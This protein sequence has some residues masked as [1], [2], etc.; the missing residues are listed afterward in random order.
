MHFS[1]KHLAQVALS[2]FFSLSVAHV[3]AASVE[4]RA[5]TCNGHPEVRISFS[6]VLYSATQLDPSCAT[7]ATGI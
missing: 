2:L 1:P 5:T 3:A 7:E 6:N 4:R